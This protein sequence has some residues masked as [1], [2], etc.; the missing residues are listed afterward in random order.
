M[1]GTGSP[2]LEVDAEGKSSLVVLTIRDCIDVEGHEN[3]WVVYER[4]RA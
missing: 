3:I 2:S 1:K 4:L